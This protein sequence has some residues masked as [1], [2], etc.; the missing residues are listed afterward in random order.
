M[1]EPLLP[2]TKTKKSEVPQYPGWHPL[3]VAA[4]DGNIEI[5]TW[6]IN[7]GAYINAVDVYGRTPL[8]YARR[9]KYGKKN[10]NVARLL[11]ENGATD[12]SPTDIKGR[13]PVDIYIEYNNGAPI[14]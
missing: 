1:K 4:F 14:F 6:L 3:H 5:A 2:K 9:R 12:F 10:D 11:I 13:T 7:D 8:H